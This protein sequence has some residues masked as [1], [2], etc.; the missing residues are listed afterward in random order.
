MQNNPKYIPG[1]DGL[2]ALSILMVLTAHLGWLDGMYTD[3]YLPKRIAFLINGNT[4]VN[5]FFT[6]SGFLITRMLLAEREKTGS[7]HLKHFFIR[8]G[9]RLL[10]PLLLFLVAAAILMF[11]DAIQVSWVGILFSVFYLYNFIPDRFYT[12]ELGHLWSLAVEEQFYLFWPFAIRWS[13]R[14]KV[15]V[16]ATFLLIAC[17][18]AQYALPLVSIVW[19]QK[20]HLLTDMFHVG[21][22]F[23]PAIGPI[24]IGSL[25]CLLVRSDKN[26]EAAPH[27]SFLL[28]SAI[29]YASPLLM[30]DVL[31]DY[32][33]YLQAM[34]I[35]L[36]LLWLLR[37][38]HSVVTRVL[39]WSPLAY[40]GRISFGV[41]IYHGLFLRTGPGGEMVVQQFPYNL[42]LTLITAVV[43]YELVEKRVLRLKEH[44]R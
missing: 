2:R 19:N 10:P 30:P 17:I 23:L 7:I 44:F 8:R 22:W 14:R 42:I 16:S 3:A 25:A 15:V 40:L 36:L 31:L 18:I 12:G 5:I 38:Q 35:V 9:L 34:G 29:L 39:E 43:S 41:Y 26:Q 13:T 24:M 33:K 32:S 21:R 1:Y 4:G 27:A 20:P 11:F 6:L 37:N 28:L